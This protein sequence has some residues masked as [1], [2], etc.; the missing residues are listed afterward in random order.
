MIELEG[1]RKTY[2]GGDTA[3]VVLE[4]VTFRIEAGLITSINL[5][6]R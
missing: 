5:S 2:G 4:D 1:I 6:P 3:T